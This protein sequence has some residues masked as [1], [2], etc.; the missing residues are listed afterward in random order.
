[1]LT[2]YWRNLNKMSVQPPYADV[3]LTRR[4]AGNPDPL[5]VTDADIITAI[6][7]SD[8]HV[9]SETAKTGIGWQTTDPV[10]PLVKEAS[11]YFAASWIIDHYFDDALK[12]DRHY[13]KSMDICMSIRESSPGSL[14]LA[15]APYQSFPLNPAGK[16]HRS[17]PGG[18]G[19]TT[20]QP[21]GQSEDD[22]VF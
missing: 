16:L 1:M 14:I 18:G 12:S 4:L 15:S 6:T 21:T 3:T 5:D 11:E 7:Y 20:L 13:Q 10:F 22:F 17:I 2:L 19:D 9:D 8:R